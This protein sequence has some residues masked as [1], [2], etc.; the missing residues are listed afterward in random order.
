MCFS[1][2]NNHPRFIACAPLKGKQTDLRRVTGTTDNFPDKNFIEGFTS[3]CRSLRVNFTMPRGGGQIKSI[4]RCNCLCGYFT[5]AV[6]QPA[7]SN[8]L[9]LLRLELRFAS[10]RVPISTGW[11]SETRFDIYQGLREPMG[12]KG[13]PV[14]L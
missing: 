2:R 6:Q 3:R 5:T 4:T 14:L 11:T 12:E 8:Q 1:V 9:L 13:R 10:T 7:A